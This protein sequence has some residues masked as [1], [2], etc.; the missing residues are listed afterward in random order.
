MATVAADGSVCEIS[1][2]P[3]A[4]TTMAAPEPGLSVCVAVKVLVPSVATVP[5]LIWS[6]VHMLFDGGSESVE[7][8]RTNLYAVPAVS[9]TFASPRVSSTT[10]FA[11]G[12][13]PVESVKVANF[14]VVPAAY[15]KR[16]PPDSA[17]PALVL[18]N[19]SFGSGEIFTAISTPS[20]GHGASRRCLCAGG[21]RF[22]A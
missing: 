9:Q 2:I 6:T 10:G 19:R 7:G 16:R 12:V 4:V 22:H 14:V 8:E 3:P 15:V 1:F 17:V 5:A 18:T 20:Q 11:F 13:A 21:L